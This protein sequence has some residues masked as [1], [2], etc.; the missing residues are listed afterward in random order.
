MRRLFSY[1]P[2]NNAE[3]PPFVP[4]EDPRDRE[5]EA[6][7]WDVNANRKAWSDNRVSDVARAR[8][9]VAEVS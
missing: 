6:L 5:E 4:T 9:Y 7:V 3:G 2:L 1:L 8:T